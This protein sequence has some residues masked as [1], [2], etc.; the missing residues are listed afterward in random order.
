MTQTAIKTDILI[1]GAGLVGTS[2]VAALGRHFR[3]TVLEH[4]LPTVV[5]QSVPDLRPITLSY[6]SYKILETL[7]LWECLATVASAIDT[8]HVSYQGALGMTRFQA[9]E[10]QVP[11]LGYVVPLFHLQQTLYQQAATKE[12]VELVAIK[13][14]T[15][16]DADSTGVTVKAETIA[17]EKIFK[18]A[19]LV[20][21]DGTHSMG[22]E[23]LNIDVIEEDL[24][25][26]AMTG[27][28]DLKE[29]HQQI[30]YERFTSEGTVAL[31]PLLDKKKYRLVWT[32]KKS[33]AEKKSSQTTTEIVAELQ[34][35]FHNRLAIADFHWENQY[36]VKQ[37]IAKELIRP[38]FVL[39]GNAAQTLYPI[40]AQGF[41]LGL[42]DAALLSEILMHAH[43]SQESLG[44][45]S[46]LQRYAAERADYADRTIK[47]THRISEVF[48]EKWPLMNRARGL[49]LLALDLIVPLKK[50]L[51]A[52]MMGLSGRVPKLARG[53][54]IE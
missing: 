33:L 6:A 52:Q 5:T 46:V 31:L 54:K 10:F 47:L 20:A 34:S 22:R 19:V 26:M 9:K 51:A 28:I 50:R 38:G 37:V 27:L 30:A 25:E 11:A 12:N 3:V 53:V 14:I 23:L 39:L 36:P 24:A 29:P 48:G 32:L 43:Q 42:R 41:N 49:G 13:T 45:F 17:G 40:A 1:I 16:I 8:V 7:R 35:L 2:L 4:H 44:D 18:A 21:A 15:Q